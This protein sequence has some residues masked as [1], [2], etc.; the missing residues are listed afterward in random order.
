MG[1][2]REVTCDSEFIKALETLGISLDNAIGDVIVEHVKNVRTGKQPLGI[3]PSGADL[4]RCD[5]EM[6]IFHTIYMQDNADYLLG[7]T[8][9]LIEKEILRWTSN[10][11]G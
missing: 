6:A 7:Y 2:Y 9:W 4:I 8:D 1:E 10:F 3:M 5:E 11:T